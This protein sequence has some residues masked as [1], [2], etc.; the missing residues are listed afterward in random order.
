MVL[1]SFS[2]ALSHNPDQ[3]LQ[4]VVGVLNAALRPAEQPKS[5]HY[6]YS[7]QRKIVELT[8][9]YQTKDDDIKIAPNSSSGWQRQPSASRCEPEQENATQES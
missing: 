5:P 8:P 3:F 7:Q 4:R 6:N 1:P 9:H 2:A